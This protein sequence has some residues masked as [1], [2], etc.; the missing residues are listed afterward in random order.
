L[1]LKVLEETK[2]QAKIELLPESKRVLFRLGMLYQEFDQKDKAK[3]VLQEYIRSTN[4]F[5]D[6]ITLE[7]RKQV[8]QKIKQ[9]N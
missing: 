1:A 4:S 6:K 2:D 8:F 7:D 3:E 9:L 5:Q